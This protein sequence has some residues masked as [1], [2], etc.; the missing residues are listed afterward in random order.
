[1]DRK[2]DRRVLRNDFSLYAGLYDSCGCG[3]KLPVGPL[4]SWCSR[5]RDGARA[6]SRTLNLVL[7]GCRH[8]VSGS[9]SEGQG[10][11]G[12]VFVKESIRVSDF[13]LEIE[14]CRIPSLCRASGS[15]DASSIGRRGSRLALQSGEPVLGNA[16]S[17]DRDGQ[18]RD[19]IDDIE[20]ALTESLA[21]DDV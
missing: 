8:G 10:V 19:R 20:T 21:A 15:G 1:M 11:S 3:W 17:L 13:G 4:A 18:S 5:N 16:R 7:R 2:Q 12:S 14:C 6:G 9:V